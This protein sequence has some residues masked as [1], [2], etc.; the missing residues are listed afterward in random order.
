MRV[1]TSALALAGVLA[2][3]GCGDTLIDHDAVVGIL[4]DPA[5]C[6][7]GQVICDGVCTTQTPGVC[8]ASCRPC[9]APPADA[10]AICT[11]TG[12]GGHDGVCGFE[13]DPGLLRCGSGCCPPALVAA[14]GEFSCAATATASG[15]QVH[16]FGAG[17]VGQLGNGV[18]GDRATSAEL[19]GV[20]G[21]TAL[22]AG[23]AHAC[24]ISGG[25]TVCWGNGAAFGAAGSVLDP[26]AVPSLAGATALAAGKS[27]TCGIVGG[28]VRCVGAE[29]AA[30]GGS[31]ALGGTALE[32][33]A[34]DGFTCA[35]VDVGAGSRQVKCWGDNAFGQLG[36]GSA[37]G[38]QTTPI[39]VANVSTAVLHVGA[40][41]RHACAGAEAR[42]GF[43]CWGDN[44]SRQ[45]GAIAAGVYPSAQLSSKVTKPVLA[46]SGGGHATC[47]MEDD[48]AWVLSCWSSDPLVAGGGVVT[49]EPNAL[50]SAPRAGAR[51]V[52][53]AGAAH[54]CLVDV[55]L[56][57]PR[58]KCFG[59]GARG[60]LG[61]GGTG[62]SP[63]PV[64]VV[65]R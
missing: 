48:G 18:A 58:L 65:D 1:R 63:T 55:T 49:G 38:A 45:L 2:L 30:G 4:A 50:P 62:S 33:A 60:R 20:A 5:T 32:L 41:A 39:A 26:A 28:Q 61:N 15:G 54:T 27:H 57:P 21:V 11:P 44:A 24:A 42:D 10:T 19:R 53:S 25:A 43:W 40:G 59:S 13:C 14:G 3:A 9:D 8:G 52:F 56:G 51:Y 7:E 23:G 22:A 17:D 35:V 12:A 16:C 37:G 46:I 29:A 6:G 34:G 47:A 31:P 64:P 36:T